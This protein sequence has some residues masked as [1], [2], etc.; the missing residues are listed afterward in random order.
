[1]YLSYQLFVVFMVRLF[2]CSTPGKMHFH[3]TYF[4]QPAMTNITA[5]QQ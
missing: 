1:M 4:G 3:P 5:S 2:V